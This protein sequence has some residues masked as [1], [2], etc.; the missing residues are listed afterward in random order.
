MLPSK[1]IRLYEEEPLKWKEVVEEKG[2][3]A[4][5]EEAVAEEAVAAAVVAV[6]D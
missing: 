6:V 3:E 1:G 2:A 5:G 4:E